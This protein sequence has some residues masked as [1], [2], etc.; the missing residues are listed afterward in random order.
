[1]SKTGR[2]PCHTFRVPLYRISQQ[3]QIRFTKMLSFHP[4]GPAPCKSTQCFICD[5][6]FH[7]HPLHHSHDFSF[8]ILRQ[9][10][11]M[12]QYNKVLARPQKCVH[13]LF[14]V[15]HCIR[16]RSTMEIVKDR[17]HINQ[18]Q[19]NST[20]YIF[21]INSTD[22]DLHRPSRFRVYVFL[23]DISSRTIYSF[24]YYV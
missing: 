7:L 14:I 6:V 5:T 19:A 4:S 12:V 17:Y 8:Y 15:D 9:I 23:L 21:L 2:R 16:L 1:M 3:V 22:P 18:T 11:P 24:I 20:V 13:T 10:Q